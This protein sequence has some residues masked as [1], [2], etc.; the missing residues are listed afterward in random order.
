M[1][2]QLFSKSFRGL[3]AYKTTFLGLEG[4]LVNLA[5]MAMPLII[6]YFLVK[7]LPPWQDRDL[8]YGQ[9]DGSSEAE[10]G[11]SA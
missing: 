11:T 2:G 9:E 8:P 3:T 4:L 10:Y 7:I 1:G 5:L 6:L